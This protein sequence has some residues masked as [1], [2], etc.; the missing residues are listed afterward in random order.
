MLRFDIDCISEMGYHT[1]TILSMSILCSYPTLAIQLVGRATMTGPHNW[2]IPCVIHCSCNPLRDEDHE[3]PSW[4]ICFS[5]WLKP[6]ISF[7]LLVIYPMISDTSS[8][9]W[10][11]H[12]FSNI[13][14]CPF[15]ANQTMVAAGW[16]WPCKRIKKQSLGS[17]E[18]LGSLDLVECILAS[19]NMFEPQC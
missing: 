4:P 11:A 6:P 16:R 10:F 17:W 18:F 19:I 2:W 5:S 13:S 3:D 15:F 9:R 1:I 7:T 12:E 14:D 8:Y